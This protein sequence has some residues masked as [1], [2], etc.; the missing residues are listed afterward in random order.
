MGVDNFSFVMAP[1]TFYKRSW[2]GPILVSVGCSTYYNQVLTSTKKLGTYCELKSFLR[3]H[4][5]HPYSSAVMYTR[6]FFSPREG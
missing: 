4:N 3:G 5:P 6:Y 1:E 2:T